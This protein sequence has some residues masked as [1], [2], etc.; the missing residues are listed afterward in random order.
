MSEY[1]LVVDVLKSMVK[2]TEQEAQRQIADLEV[3]LK[4]SEIPETYRVIGRTVNTFGVLGKAAYIN[5]YSRIARKSW[6]AGSLEAALNNARLTSVSPDW[7]EFAQ[8]GHP[9]LDP[10]AAQVAQIALTALSKE[11]DLALAA[12]L[13]GVSTPLKLSWDK[14]AGSEAASVLQVIG[15]EK[16]ALI[17]FLDQHHIPHCFGETGLSM[18]QNFADQALARQKLLVSLPPSRNEPLNARLDLRAEPVSSEPSHMPTKVLT[19][20]VSEGKPATGRGLQ[21]SIFKQVKRETG[22]SDLS[23]I[24]NEVWLRLLD[25]ARLPDGQRERYLKQYTG[26]KRIGYD[27]EGT[28]GFD[29]KSLRQNIRDWMEK[30][31]NTPRDAV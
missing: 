21:K 8:T 27:G 20:R 13:S 2:A 23:E 26:G 18:A 17:A 28:T 12:H 4:L 16:A 7:Y 30:E 1:V 5:L 9:R 24:A 19:H 22:S 31:G 10:N 11:F 25:A 3:M 29:K 14:A 6:S 15:F